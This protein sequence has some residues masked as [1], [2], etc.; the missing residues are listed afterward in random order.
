MATI[1]DVAVKAHVSTAT[2]SRVLN[3]KSSVDPTLVERVKRAAR[4]LG[5][6]P[7]GPARSLRTRSTAM[8][9][10]IISDVQSP[11]FTSLA[12]GVEDV[13]HRRG[14]SVVLCN[15]DDDP[16]KERHYVDVA[17]KELAAGV[18][19][20]PTSHTTDVR[21]LVDRGTPV[22][23]VDRPIHEP[24]CDQVLVDIRTAAADATNHLLEE[25]YR[26]IGCITGPAGR[27]PTE[28][29]LAG[30]H[31][32]LAASGYDYQDRFVRCAQDRAGAAARAAGE[33]LDQ[34]DRP[35]ALLLA[36]TT[37]A[38]GALA[39][40][41]ARQLRPGE[42]VGIVAFDDAP[43]TTLLDPSLSVIDQPAY[44]LGV[45]ATEC[46]FAKLSGPPTAMKRVV[47]PA[48]LIKRGSSHRALN[49]AHA[50][51]RPC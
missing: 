44:D 41:S 37:M 7:N 19:L 31:E 12:R 21:M 23:S 5:Y 34:L 35:D 46:L 3:G 50:P 32:A 9:A 10:L 43:W 33:L 20:C 11:F 36:N 40:L 15:A 47:L 1:G 18:L 48:R 45:T 8:I 14:Y 17:A 28:Q 22:V 2:V 13:A 24:G 49:R 29:K 51:A 42:D 38:I 4:E 39:A 30:Y 6:H 16:D 27:H 26:R 25:G